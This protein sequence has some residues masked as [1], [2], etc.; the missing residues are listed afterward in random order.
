MKRAPRKT[1]HRKCTKIEERR[2]TEILRSPTQGREEP[3]E[4]E[5][6][7]KAEILRRAAAGDR[8]EEEKE[9]KKLKS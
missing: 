7:T 1:K 2:K 6:E 9:R 8:E 3:E 4:E 5:A